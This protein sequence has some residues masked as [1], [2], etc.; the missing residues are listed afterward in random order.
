MSAIL[1]TLP[2]GSDRSSA[3]DQ[4]TAAVWPAPSAGSRTRCGPRSGATRSR[5]IVVHL[6]DGAVTQVRSMGAHMLRLLPVG[7]AARLPS[8]GPEGCVGENKLVGEPSDCQTYDRARRD[9]EVMC[10]SEFIQSNHSREEV[11]KE[12]DDREIGD[13]R[14]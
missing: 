4:P 5:C 10:T 11:G 6:L 8:N 14:E 12:H 7:D 2:S 9:L 13:Q 3:W 1:P